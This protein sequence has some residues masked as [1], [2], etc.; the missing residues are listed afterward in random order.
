[1]KMVNK[2]TQEKELYKKADPKPTKE[3]I[4]LKTNEKEAKVVIF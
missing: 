4:P 1:M 3:Y 2:E